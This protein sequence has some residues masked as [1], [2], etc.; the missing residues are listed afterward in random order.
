MKRLV[1]VVAACLHCWS[2]LRVAALISPSQGLVV[3]PAA[4]PA[5]DVDWRQGRNDSL[6][7]RR[8]VANDTA[9]RRTGYLNSSGTI[10]SAGDVNLDLADGGAEETL[11][12][13]HFARAAASEALESRSSGGFVEPAAPPAPGTPAWDCGYIFGVSKVVWA[14]I[15]SVLALVLLLACIP[16]LL[17]CVKRRTHGAPVFDCRGRACDGL[18]QDAGAKRANL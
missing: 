8:A 12:E 6:Q 3:A 2:P 15:C 11:S 7:M 16:L 1:V 17:L 5:A 14:V 9:A 18:L 4:A 13:A 10:S